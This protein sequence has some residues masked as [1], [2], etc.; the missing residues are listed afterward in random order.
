MALDENWLRPQH[1]DEFGLVM[2]EAILHK[3]RLGCRIPVDSQ[4]WADMNVDVSQMTDFLAEHVM[5]QFESTAFQEK[6]PPQTVS[7]E[8]T[9][10]KIVHIPSWHPK[11]PFQFWKKKH[12]NGRWIGW[13]VRQLGWV[14]YEKHTESRVIEHTETVTIELNHSVVYPEAKAIASPHMGSTV[15]RWVEPVWQK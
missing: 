7:K 14:E 2:K 10:E 4:I 9:F 5:V 11:S 3:V 12:W 13:F 1:T 8:V 15:I 6:L